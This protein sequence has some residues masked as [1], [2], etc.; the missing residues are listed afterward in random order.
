MRTMATGSFERF[1]S[2]L[3]SAVRI[4][5]CDKELQ[6]VRTEA[7][8]LEGNAMQIRSHK[9]VRLGPVRIDIE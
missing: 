8:P 9:V 1:P 6:M 3:S 2:I 4:N 7:T 5:R